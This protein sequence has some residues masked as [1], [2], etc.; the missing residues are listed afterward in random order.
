MLQNDLT[1]EDLMVMYQNGS[2]SAF[3]VLYTRH[4][5]KIYGF[6]KSRILRAEKTADIYQEVFI[7]IHRSKHL[8]NKSLPVLPWLFTV[9][10]SVMIDEIRKDK[11]SKL[12]DD[13]KDLDQILG[14]I[15][16]SSVISDTVLLIQKLPDSQKIALQMRY[17][18]DKT[19]EE[20][21]E[22][23]KTSPENVRQIISRGIKRLKDLVNKEEG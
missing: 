18:D 16:E 4:S 21:S 13:D 14:E 9:T 19:F 8:Y 23:L 7:K 6:L 2:E 12:I 5:S 22:T 17:V 10:K 20:I 1:D 15:F 11:K 3:Q